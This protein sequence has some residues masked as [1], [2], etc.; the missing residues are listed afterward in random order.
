MTPA[1][2]DG[3]REKGESIWIRWWRSGR[4]RCG[5]PAGRA[6]RSGA[7]RS[8]CAALTGQ[9]MPADIDGVLEDVATALDQIKTVRESLLQLPGG[10][11]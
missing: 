11:V 2:R 4:R 3:C 9:D 1:S 10:A 8:I 7:V 5:R 6:T